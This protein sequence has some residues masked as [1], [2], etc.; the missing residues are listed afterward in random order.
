MPIYLFG[1][2]RWANLR[3]KMTI[4]SFGNVNELANL[5]GQMSIH[6][7]RNVS[8]LI[9]DVRCLFTYYSCG[10]STATIEYSACVSV[11]L[12]VYTITKK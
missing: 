11:C 1:N 8:E 6:L 2:V 10:L 3:G 4:C 12:V 7:F 5:E 9:W